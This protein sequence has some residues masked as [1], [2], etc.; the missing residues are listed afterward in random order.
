MAYRIEYSDEAESHLAR[1]TVREQRIVRTAVVEQLTHQPTMETRN[2]KRRRPNPLA[3]W[4]LRVEPFR[5]L[6]DVEGETV[7]VKAVGEKRGERLF[8]GGQ[9][10]S[11]DG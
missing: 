2:R 6:Y 4:Q 9:E 1:L 10:V 5:V 11:S 7:Y 8:V 3:Q